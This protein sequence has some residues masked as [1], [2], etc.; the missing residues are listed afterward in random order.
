MDEVVDFLFGSF[1]NFA[2]VIGIITLVLGVISA[3]YIVVRKRLTGSINEV[4][5]K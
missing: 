1:L 2:I 5:Y 3:I 4:D